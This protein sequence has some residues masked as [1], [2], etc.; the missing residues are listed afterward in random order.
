MKIYDKLITAILC[1]GHLFATNPPGL[2][3]MGVIERN[4]RVKL[5]ILYISI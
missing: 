2:G 5:Y 4:Q 1:F 3:L